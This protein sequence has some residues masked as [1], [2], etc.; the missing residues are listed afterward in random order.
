MKRLFHPSSIRGK[1]TAR[2]LVI[3]A[4][5]SLMHASS[6]YT[7]YQH[8]SDLAL[9]AQQNDQ[10]EVARLIA[11]SIDNLINDTARVQSA[12]G[13]FLTKSRFDPASAG[14][15]LSATCKAFPHFISHSLLF[16][17]GKVAAGS[18]PGVIGLDFSSRED[19]RLTKSGKNPAVSHI[20]QVSDKRQCFAV[21]SAIYDHGLLKGIVRTEIDGKILKRLVRTKRNE[22]FVV[23]SPDRRWSALSQSDAFRSK[24]SKTV[25][26]Q[27]SFARRALLRGRTESSTFELRNSER[28]IGCAIPIRSAGWVLVTASPLDKTLGPTKAILTREFL[29]TLLLTATF[30]LVFWWQCGVS[31]LANL[32]RL[33]LGAAAVAVG[34]FGKR[35][36][37]RT[38]DEFEDLAT[39]FNGMAESLQIRDRQIY[40]KSAAL[41]SLLDV[42]QVVMSS[43]DL[44]TVAAAI[45]Q[46]VNR[47]FGARSVAVYLYD[48]HSHALDLLLYSGYTSVV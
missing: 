4:L 16:P 44:K 45:S 5:L 48:D 2:L 34:D 7:G 18:A 22:D 13:I 8:Q 11:A 39:A 20:Y 43:L 12:N 38:G 17:D 14:Q 10:R 46:A 32:H 23:M 37:I 27:A 24:P 42:A 19:V 36:N 28:Y 31:L 26:E 25:L 3:F 6:Y 21:S 9:K 15:Y 30:L 33:S 1:L 41:Q 35:I 40:N 47:R 29:I